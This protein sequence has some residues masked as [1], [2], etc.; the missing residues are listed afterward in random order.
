MFDVC[1]VVV[2]ECTA[3]CIV[4]VSLAMMVE[5]DYGRVDICWSLFSCS[6]CLCL[7]R[8]DVS[9]CLNIGC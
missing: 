3:T 4:S 6:N 1:L 9:C 7:F 8:F 5:L 2:S